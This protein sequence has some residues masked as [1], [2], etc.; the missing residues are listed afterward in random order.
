V[1]G[2]AIFGLKNLPLFMKNLESV[3]ELDQRKS[4]W[5]AEGIGAARVEWDAEIY[6]EIE[7]ELIAWRSLEN[8]DV[9]NG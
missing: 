8:A 7:N 3:V 5:V 9:V 4:H 1:T 2:G 6:N